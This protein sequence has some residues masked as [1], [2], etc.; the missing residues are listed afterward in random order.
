MA[1]PAPGYDLRPLG[2]YAYSSCANNGVSYVAPPDVNAACNRNFIV[3]IS[4]GPIDN[5][6]NNPGLAL[7]RAAVTAEGAAARYT[8]VIPVTPSGET[9]SNFAD[10]WARFLNEVKNV[11][12]FTINANDKSTGQAL[13]HAAMM[14]SMATNGG[15]DACN[16]NDPASIQECLDATFNK[17]LEVNSV[18]ASVSLPV[19]VNPQLQNL[20]QV[21]MA[22]FRPD[23]EGNP[24]WFGNLKQFQLAIDTNKNPFIADSLGNRAID[25]TTGQVF[26]TAISYWTTGSTY[27]SYS[28]RGNPLSASDSPDGPLVEKAARRS[29]CARSTR[30]PARRSQPERSSPASVVRRGRR[31]SLSPAAPTRVL[32]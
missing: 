17:I 27:W 15:G 29:A 20:D 6:D 23:P 8:Q 32:A 24:R 10:E 12:T 14:R 13:N 31:G 2:S 16:A 19:S 26:P 3:F 30:Q 28:P 18:F 11:Q 25:A 9:G 4:N 5:S 22:M 21:Y 1:S 7:L